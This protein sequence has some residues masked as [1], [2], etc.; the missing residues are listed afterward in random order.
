MI[1]KNESSPLKWTF[2]GC[3][4]LSVYLRINSVIYYFLTEI[5]MENTDV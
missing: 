2:S 3:S 5:K 1:N 4:P